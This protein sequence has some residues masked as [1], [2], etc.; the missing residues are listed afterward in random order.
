[1]ALL[2]K[3]YLLSLVGL[4]AFVVM[5]CDSALMREVAYHERIGNLEEARTAAE[6][7][8]LADPANSE[9]HYLLGRTLLAQ[10]DYSKAHTAFDHANARTPRYADQ[11]TYLLE[12]AYRSVMAE[13]A[14]AY[15]TARF[16]DA[17]GHFS[18]ATRI[19][20]V[21]LDAY[22]ALGHASIQAGVRPMA[23]AAYRTASRLAPDDVEIWNNLAELTTLEADYEAALGYSR[24]VLELDP[25]FKPALRRLAHVEEKMGLYAEAE[26]HYRQLV[27]GGHTQADA[28]NFAFL[29]Y[30][31]QNFA[32][33]LPHLEVLADH[34]QPD[35]DVLK[36]LR[37]LSGPGGFHT[38]D[39]CGHPA[40]RK[41]A[42]GPRRGE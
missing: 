11:I 32:E 10:G 7:V 27:D 6:R 39:R 8:T 30:N 4:L 1:M 13:G 12:S 16:A 26:A 25:T 23:I 28:R 22:R 5:G 40:A 9:A 42:R 18:A 41:P 35:W 34:G 24:R 20:T 3:V 36:V 31:R 29:L 17:A 15:G 21:S 2:D 33:A 37:K 38:G 19:D 14:T